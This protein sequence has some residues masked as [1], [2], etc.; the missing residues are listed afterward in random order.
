MSDPEGVSWQIL[1]FHGCGGKRLT[2]GFPI[3]RNLPCLS[4]PSFHLRFRGH[5]VVR[6]VVTDGCGKRRT[7]NH[8]TQVH[9]QV[10]APQAQHRPVGVQPLAHRP[11][12]RRG[13]QDLPHPG[14]QD[15]APGRKGAR[16]ADRRPGAEGR[17][18]GR[19]RH[20]AR[21][22]GRLPLLQGEVEHHRALHREELPGAEQAHL[23]LPGKR[24]PRGP[25]GAGGEPL[26]GQ[27]DRKRL[28][29]E[30]GGQALPAAEAGAQV[31]HVAGPGAQERVRV[32]QAAQARED[33][34][35]RARPRR[36]HANAQARRGG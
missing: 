36:A 15:A 31:G 35:K 12:N 32:L 27:H 34:H 1:Q 30:V 20:R 4:F 28:R 33:A 2:C 14:G 19:R 11:R 8:G 22:H 16:R 29:A 6:M 23:H 10:A 26:D 25:V 13:G 18:R 7:E 21:L 5:L 17:R 9:E 24:R 3:P